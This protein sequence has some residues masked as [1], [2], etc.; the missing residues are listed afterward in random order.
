MTI[1]YEKFIHPEDRAGLKILKNT[2]GFDALMKGYLSI[3]DE[4]LMRGI[5]MASMIRL[6]PDQLPELYKPLPEICSTLGIPEPELYLEMDPI[7]NAH[8]F[9]DTNP[10]IV[11]KSGLV[12]MLS[13]EE[14]KVVIAHECGHILCHHVLYHTV[15][16]IIGSVGGGL[17][18]P[19]TEPV[20]WALKHWIRRSEFSADRVAA[21]AVGNYEDVVKVMIRLAG[22]SSRVTEKVNIEE[23]FRQV[24]KYKETRDD[25]TYNKI[26][27]AWAIKNADHPFSGIRAVEVK[28]WFMENRDNLPENADAPKKLSW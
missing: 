25:S 27:Q 17:L 15:G 3:V 26:L 16:A 12:E 14:L 7:P 20:T 5:N 24:E 19:V 11:I 28:K 10:Y 1:D 6:G 2:L 9:G 4:R 13:P 22:G 21:Y 18:L 23:Y 8:T